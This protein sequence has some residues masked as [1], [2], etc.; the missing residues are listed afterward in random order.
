MRDH[1]SFVVEARYRRFDGEY[2]LLRT[3][4]HPRF[5]PLGDF[6]GMIGVNVDITETRSPSR[7]SAA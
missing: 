4:A 1:M 5:G 2:R 3:D 6:L 7:H